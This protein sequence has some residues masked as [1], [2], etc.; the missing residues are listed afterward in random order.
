ML[1]KLRELNAEYRLED[2]GAT[3]LVPSARVA[4]TRLQLAVAGCQ[5]GRIGFEVSTRPTSARRSSPNRSHPPCLEGELS[6]RSCPGGGRAGARA[7]DLAKD[8]VFAE[9]RQPAKASVLVK[10]GRG[11]RF[12]AEGHAICTSR[13]TPW[14]DWSRGRSRSSTCRGIF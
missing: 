6:G 1:A 14:R 8:S 11:W 9:K 13:P 2:N 10:R 7:P 3:V 4:E 5:V 12:A